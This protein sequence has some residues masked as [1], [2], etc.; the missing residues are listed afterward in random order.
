MSS[1]SVPPPPA[2]PLPR[3]ERSLAVC[4]LLGAAAMAA[5]DEIVFHQLLHWHHFYDRSTSG[6]GLL[7]DGLLHTA[8]LLG[9]VAGFFLFADLRRR[10]ALAPAHAWA[11]LFLGLGGFQLFDGIVDHKLLRVHQIRYGVDVTGYDWAWNGAGAALFL[12]GA[13]LAV[14]ARGRAPG[15]RTAT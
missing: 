4:A 1:R 8:E 3:P 10:R 13:A 11:G 7:S 9:L 15:G 5:V 12:L 2:G 14:R 6:V